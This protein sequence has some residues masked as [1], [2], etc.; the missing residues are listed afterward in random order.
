[1][2][3]DMACKKFNG[4]SAASQISRQEVQNLLP[5]IPSARRVSLERLG[6]RSI[7]RV[8]YAVAPEET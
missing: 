8:G 4:D 3:A 7:G 1:M 6:L 2:R 5:S